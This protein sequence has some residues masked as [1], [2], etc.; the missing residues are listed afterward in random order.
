MRALIG[1]PGTLGY[2]LPG[3]GR[4]DRLIECGRRAARRWLAEAA[5]PTV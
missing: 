2:V 4:T 5:V 3:L 1:S